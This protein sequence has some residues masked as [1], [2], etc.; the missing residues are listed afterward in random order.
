[1]RKPY[2]VLGA[3]FFLAGLTLGCGGSTPLENGFGGGGGT[4]NV[5]L[6]MGDTP[7]AGVTV[8]SF[9]VSLTGAVLQ[10]GNVNLLTTPIRIEVKQL[11]VELAFLN[12][13]QVPAGTYTSIQLTFANP[14]LTFLNNTGATLAGCS[15]GQVC[16]IVP[17]MS[18]LTVNFSGAPFPLTIQANSQIGL[19][20]DFDLQNSLSQTLSVAPV[21]AVQVLPAV[22]GTGQIEEIEDV[23]GR[24]V[25]VD[26]ANNRFTLQLTLSGQQLVVTVDAQTRFEDFNEI[27]CAANNITCIQVGQVLE[28]DLRILAGGVLR[29]RKVEF[30]DDAN[31]EEVE[32]II[33]AV[34]STTQFQMVVLNEVPDIAG[35]D[36]GSLISVTIQTGASFRIDENGLTIPGDLRFDSGADLLVGQTVQVRR[37]SGSSGTN[38]IT[39]RVRLRRTRFTATVQTPGAQTFQV[40]QLPSLFTSN[41]ITSIEVRTSAD[42]DFDNVSGAAALVAGDRVS[43]RGLLFRRA[44]N[45]PVLVAKKVRKR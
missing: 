10:P 18:P 28:V 7:P 4:G 15:N 5:A 42:T 27:N 2:F 24:V 13:L 41:G 31:A 19:L 44:S 43:L 33:V 39:D 36:V 23:F 38:V 30:E 20:V 12:A 16:K 11:E 35:I 32:G 26:A 40:N 29:A 3:I 6:M 14:E 45:I 1:M 25:S 21:V 9:Q 37:R 8:L 34:Q 17:P 22:Q